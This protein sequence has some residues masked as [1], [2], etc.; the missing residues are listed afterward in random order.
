MKGSDL[1]A[2]NL[3]SQVRISW[4]DWTRGGDAITGRLER[5]S[6]SGKGTKL[7]LTVGGE[8]DGATT[9]TIPNAQGLDVEVTA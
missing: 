3:G 6:H 1:A 8:L 9:V 5:V 2:D 4:G 7:K